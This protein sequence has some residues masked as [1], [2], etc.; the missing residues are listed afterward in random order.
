[1]KKSNAKTLFTKVLSVALAA[2]MLLSPV[3][4]FA[5]NTFQELQKEITIEDTTYYD[6]YDG[7]P[8]DRKD[9]SDNI[10]FYS[11]ILTKGGLLK[12]W[13]GLS[14]NI[15]E[16]TEHTYSLNNKKTFKENFGDGYY[17]D[18][19][20][21]LI[22]KKN[23]ASSTDDSDKYVSSGLS[24]ARNFK[25]LELAMDNQ[26][27]KLLNR[28]GITHGHFEKCAPIPAMDDDKDQLILYTTAANID[29]HGG[30]SKFTYNSFGLA[31]Y[32]FELAMVV[33]DEHISSAIGDMSTE[34]AVANPPK[35]F[36]FSED[37]IKDHSIVTNKNK[38]EIISTNSIGISATQTLSNSLTNSESY[39]YT[40]TIGTGLSFEK[41]FGIP[42]IGDLK[43]GA[44]FSYSNSS[45]EVFGSS[46]TNEKVISE[47]YNQ[48]QSTDTPVAP[49]SV[50][51]VF[52][53]SGPT[54]MKTKYDQ[55]ITISYKVMIFSKNGNLYADN[56]A[57]HDV[58]NY[59]HY[60]FSS[61]FGARTDTTDAVINLHNRLN[62]TSN[63]GNYESSYGKTLLNKYNTSDSSGDLQIKEIATSLDWSQIKKSKAQG[64]H[65]DLKNAESI[66]NDMYTRRPMSATGGELTEKI[67]ATNTTVSKLIPLYPLAAIVA[68]HERL[69]YPNTKVGAEI[70]LNPIEL[71]AL[72]VNDI[73]YVGFSKRTGSWILVDE[74]DE[75]LDESIAT[76]QSTP[77]DYKYSVIAQGPG[78][79]YAKY[80][81]PEDTYTWFEAD[82]GVFTKNGDNLTVPRVKIEIIDEEK[83]P[84]NGT[85]EASGEATITVNDDPVHIDDI[86]TIDA[87]VLDDTD[88][89][90][91]ADLIWETRRNPDANGNGLYINENYMRAT[92]VGIYQIRATYRKQYSD[93]IDVTVLSREDEELTTNELTRGDLA[94]VLYY[95]GNK[96]G[97]TGKTGF[98]DIDTSDIGSGKYYKDAVLWALQYNILDGHSSSEFKLDGNVTKEQF[99]EAMYKFAEY[100]GI[101]TSI[102]MKPQIAKKI[103]ESGITENM[104]MAV[105]WALTKGWIAEDDL[106]KLQGA[107][108]T[109]NLKELPKSISKEPTHE[110]SSVYKTVEENE[111]VESDSEE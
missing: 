2:T 31:F 55:P 4:V 73:P 61:E 29:K 107:A 51:E 46:V 79:A 100:K 30:T 36:S 14:Y 98:S 57:I 6:I 7:K 90:I 12:K 60:T 62:P 47:T 13:S 16:M 67:H 97:I 43:I 111:E 39:S 25:D 83:K 84:F 103:E 85:V 64:I 81:I 33:D 45:S 106:A 82:N 26:L 42:K 24:V 77:K 20:D 87:F 10:A 9:T 19:V 44:S 8:N 99:I 48:Q 18:L 17:F 49:H 50:L 92:K 69:Y 102:D 94:L 105:S 3:E 109:E 37:L 101:D 110:E 66:A 93:W 74:N 86:D 95:L 76:I 75:P 5:Y 65:K 71:N 91:S 54:T 15:F 27:V 89:E 59:S 108:T 68:E 80:M 41:I 70:K 52:Q 96:E 38:N 34:E 32:D 63:V 1:M 56:A 53:E 35:G 21:A 104:Q 28:R 78:V 22:N 23:V 88:K 11:D 40:D 72:N 58:E